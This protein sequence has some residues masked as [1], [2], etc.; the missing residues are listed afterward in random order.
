MA[1]NSQHNTIKLTSDI[2]DKEIHFL[3]VTVRKDTYGNLSTT[4]YTKPTDAH[5]YLH[6]TSFHPKHQ[7]KSI[8]YS[9]A[10]RIRRIC[11]TEESFLECSKLLTDN[12]HAHGY[13]KAL[14]REA[15]KKAK[16]NHLNDTKHNS[17]HEIIPL[18]V[19]N[20]P[21]LPNINK[22]IN[23]YEHL[24]KTDSNLAD[25]TKHKI[26]TVYRRTSVWTY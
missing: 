18:I 26:L 19:T 4:L 13:P 5:M 3:G 22:I 16:I 11:S 9:Q 8:L 21:R 10:L 6:Y 17:S 24:L 12:L 14:I 23:K 15:I 25:L 7:K 20:N 2:S 1:L